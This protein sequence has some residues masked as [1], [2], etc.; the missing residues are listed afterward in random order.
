MV[1]QDVQTAIESVIRESLGSSNVLDIRA[2]RD[3]SAYQEDETLQVTVY[4][5]STVQDLNR[6]EVLGLPRTIRKV[7]RT[8]G[9]GAFPIVSFIT[10][11]DFKAFA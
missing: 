3:I 2:V 6:I 10:R 9:E 1:D 7:L 11:N 8:V 5:K 4:I